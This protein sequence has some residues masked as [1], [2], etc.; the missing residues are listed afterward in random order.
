MSNYVHG[1]SGDSA[2]DEPIVPPAIEGGIAGQAR[3]DGKGQARNAHSVIAASEPQSGLDSG[4]HAAMSDQNNS[5]VGW[6]CG[7]TGE[8][9]FVPEAMPDL[10]TAHLAIDTEIDE[11]GDDENGN[12]GELSDES[13]VEQL[14]NGEFQADHIPPANGVNPS[15]EYELARDHE[16]LTDRQFINQ[17]S[18]ETRFPPDVLAANADLISDIDDLTTQYGTHRSALL[19]ILEGLRDR[20]RQINAVAM[21]VVA[22]RLGISAVDVE[23]VVTFYHFLGRQPTGKHVIHVCRTIS[24]ALKGMEQVVQRLERETGVSMDQTTTDGSVTLEWANCIGLCDQAPAILVDRAAVG[25]VTPDQAAN[26]ITM[27]R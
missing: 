4:D 24:C 11:A 1:G 22:D 9:R 25:P 20:R 15:R 21:Q 3:N 14:R 26:I 27:L 19:P 5:D 23:G 7:T 18:E 6:S 8:G 12:W 13:V 2:I 10:E 16:A 17:S